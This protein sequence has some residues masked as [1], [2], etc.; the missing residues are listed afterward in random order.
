M[1]D[2]GIKALFTVNLNL[3]ARSV[4]CHSNY[5]SPLSSTGPLHIHVSWLSMEGTKRFREVTKVFLSI[6]AAINTNC[7]LEFSL[8]TASETLINTPWFIEIG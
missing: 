1:R 7:A 6:T 2:R 8:T 5:T 4:T 3:K